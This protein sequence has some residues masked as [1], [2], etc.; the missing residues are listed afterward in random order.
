MNNNN[1]QKQIE[2]PSVIKP[3]AQDNIPSV[4][5]KPESK[6]ELHVTP[7]VVN[8]IKS[9]TYEIENSGNDLGA[10]A[11]ET[12]VNTNGNIKS[13]ENI[14]DVVVMNYKVEAERMEQ[15]VQT[16]LSTEI[17]KMNNLIIK[18]MNE[19]HSIESF[20]IPEKVEELK[21]QKE[22]VNSL[23][24]TT[25]YDVSASLSSERL[26]IMQL[27]A[28]RTKEIIRELKK[29][30]VALQ[31]EIDQTKLGIEGLEM[32]KKNINFFNE[33]VLK[34]RLSLFLNHWLIALAN[35]ETNDDF[36]RETKEVFNDYLTKQTALL[37]A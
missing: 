19:I 7:S 32:Q 8:L 21:M 5:E 16:E 23:M 17:N 30:V 2:A 33:S 10:Y 9:K 26:L 12:C 27:A 6:P 3:E 25:E 29:K 22:Q 28:A 36:I 13:F 11:M 4:Y 15:D 14:L 20:A 34:R 35:M 37:A 31:T 1:S 18:T 24:N